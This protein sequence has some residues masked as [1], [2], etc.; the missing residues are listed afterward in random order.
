MEGVVRFG[1][2]EGKDLQWDVLKETE[3]SQLLLCRR[4]IGSVNMY[5][6]RWKDWGT[7]EWLNNEFLMK[8]FTDQD[9]IRIVNARILTN[10]VLT[11][12]NVFILSDEEVKAY[13]K[14]QH[15]KNRDYNY[16]LTR[17]KYND[18]SNYTNYCY[19]SNAICISNSSSSY[20]TYSFYPALYLK[21]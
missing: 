6:R 21:K 1:K 15:F 10:N 16:I 17:S 12:D 19:Y 3:Y 9:R 14:E 4:C 13:M 11:K 20:G 2:W 18:N 8:A 7:R 5:G